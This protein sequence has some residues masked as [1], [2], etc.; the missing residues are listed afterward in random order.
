MA[1]TLVCKSEKPK[2]NILLAF[3]N[4]KLARYHLNPSLVW[5]FPQNLTCLAPFRAQ[6]V[7]PKVHFIKAMVID[8][9]FQLPWLIIVLT[10]MI[11][12]LC[13][14]ESSWLMTLCVSNPHG[15]W[16]FFQSSWMIILLFLI[17]MVDE[18]FFNLHGW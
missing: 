4:P 10:F 3:P 9:F 8:L 15:W 17:F 7:I 6:F 5:D 18:S 16:I 2:S 11:N 12:N 1:W 14:F 13:Y